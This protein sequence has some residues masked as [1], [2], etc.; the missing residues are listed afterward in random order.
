MKN[1]LSQINNFKD[2]QLS[3]V[4]I[5]LQSKNLHEDIHAHSAFGDISSSDYQDLKNLLDGI[6]KNKLNAFIATAIKPVKSAPSSDVSIQEIFAQKVIN[7]CENTKESINSKA[8]IYNMGVTNSSEASE[9]YAVPRNLD[10]YK[11]IS[12]AQGVVPVLRAVSCDGGLAGHDWVTFSFGQS[13]LGKNLYH[14]NAA[15]TEVA[16]SEAIESELDPLLHEIF[17]FGLGK[18][19]EKGMHFYKYSY[20]LQDNLGLVLFGHSSKRISVQINGTGCSLARKGWQTQLYKFLKEDVVSPKLNRVDLAFDDLDGDYLNLDLVN[21]WD[22][23]DLFW[24][25]GVH[26]EINHLGNWKRINGKGRT[27]T[28]GNRT[29]GKF[30][31]FY[32]RGKKEGDSLSLWVRAEIEFKST[33]RHI[34]LEILLAPSQYFK[35]AYPALEILASIVGDYCTPEKTEIVKKQSKINVQKAIEITKHQFGK[36]I[37]QFRKFIDDTVLLDMISSNEDDMPKRLQFSH[38]AV[39][40]SVR[41]NQPT[42]TNHVEELPLF[43]GLF[44]T[45]SNKGLHYAI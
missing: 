43:V 3:P 32:E 12:T 39:M 9:S 5:Y 24:C 15:D 35:G 18:K 17:G 16:L 41:L 13:T 29:S 30:G 20:E 2:A 36:Y 7:A 19:R 25:S 31:R 1:L 37:R 21:E 14:L 40:Q 11:L 26:P 22:D 33:D 28:I 44:D 10:N 4:D 8:P 6:V 42:F 23:K 27:I 38:A 45:N 34:P